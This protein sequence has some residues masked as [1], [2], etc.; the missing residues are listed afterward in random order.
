MLYGHCFSP[1]IW[2]VSLRTFN[3]KGLKFNGRNQ[4]I[5]YADDSNW[6]GGSAHNIKKNT[7]ALLAACKETG[8][9]ENAEKGKHGCV[10]LG[11]NAW[12]VVSY[13]KE[14]NPLKL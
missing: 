11:Q 7:E 4:L 9:E 12:E 5:F 6:L 3:Q 13:R 2:F 8:L 1:L 10:S 14:T